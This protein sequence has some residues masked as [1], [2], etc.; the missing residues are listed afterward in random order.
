MTEGDGT[1][2]GQADPL[3][4]Q[5]RESFGR[6]VYTHKTH[7]K[8]ADRCAATLRRYKLAQIAVS[9]LTA[10]GALSIIVVDAEWLKV[11]TAALSIVGLW[12]SG[13][14]KG[15]DP[16]GTAQKHRDTAASL[17]SVRESY[18][19]LLT[20]IRRGGLTAD[21][22]AERRDAL[23]EE[24]AAIYK[25]APQTNDKAYGDAQ[26][27]LKQLE[28]MTFSDSEIDAFLPSSLHKR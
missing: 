25:G 14:M 22:A 20:D 12:I 16:G 8:M 2:A 27:A 19:S 6:V 5:V 23:Q 11:A 4:D 17:W 15:F 9:V 18:Q 13:Y 1:M 3:E 26:T 21:Q 28:D 7:E 10:S 24:L